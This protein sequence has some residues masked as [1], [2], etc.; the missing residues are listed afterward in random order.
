MTTKDQLKNDLTSALKAGDK[1]AVSTLRS[2]IGAIQTQEKAGKTAVEFDEEQVLNVLAK[3]SKKR[4]DTSEEF[5]KLGYTERAD[6]EQ[7][8]AEIILA[9]LP[10]SASYDDIVTVVSSI[11]SQFDAPTQRDMGTIMKQAKE[12]FGAAVDGRQLS[13]I[14]RSMIG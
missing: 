9:Y 11:M 13:D 2:V 12:H 3:E 14:V 6:T 7:A 5:R 4:L 10:E 1:L 8:E